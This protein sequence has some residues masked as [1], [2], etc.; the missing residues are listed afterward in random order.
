VEAG[1]VVLH[2]VT[3][4]IVP[5]VQRVITQLRPQ[6]L[7]QRLDAAIEVAGQELHVRADP[8]R[9]AQILVNLIGNAIHYTPDD[10]SITVRA[11]SDGGQAMITVED[12]G[13]GIPAHALPFLFER[14]YRVDPSRSRS[15]GGSGIG[16]TI[17]RHLAWAM[18]GDITAASAGSGQ[19]SSFTLTLPVV[20]RSEAEK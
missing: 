8:D 15:S 2:S 1:Q 14:F 19:G 17:A 11:R 5:L 6:L 7:G 10:G 4:D 16:L 9:T 20:A 3:F 18:G 13:V 12:T